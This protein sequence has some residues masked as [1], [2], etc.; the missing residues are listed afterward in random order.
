MS[1]PLF[2]S[3][4]ILLKALILQLRKFFTQAQELGLPV[5]ISTVYRTL[6]RLKTTGNVS[7]VSGDRKIRYEATDGGPEHDH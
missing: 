3:L 7:T 2:P 4:K 6:H 1:L 5:S